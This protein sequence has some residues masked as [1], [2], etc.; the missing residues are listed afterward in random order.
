MIL[1][2]SLQSCGTTSS[3]TS[4]IKSLDVAEESVASAIDEIDNADAFAKKKC[5]KPLELVDT[6]IENFAIVLAD[7]MTKAAN[8]Y[9]SHNLLR[10]QSD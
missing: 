7:A 5:L 9:N 4:S 6:S 2:L 1:V 10:R 8:C 3:K